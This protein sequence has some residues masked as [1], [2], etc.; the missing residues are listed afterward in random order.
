VSVPFNQKMK[1]YT[2]LKG[3]TIFLF[4]IAGVAL[5]LSIFF[6][7]FTKA[8]QLLLPLLIVVSYLLII[9]FLF[10]F[11]PATFFKNLRPSLCVY[12]V[13][14]SQVLEV[15]TWGMSFFYVIKA[16]G[17]FG[18]FFAFLF[19]FLAPM[20]LI[21]ATLKG[22]WA[23]AGHL[24]IWIS[25]TYGMKFYSQWLLNLNSRNQKKRDIIDVDA[26]EVQNS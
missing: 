1:V 18:I 11:L 21:G 25:F 20:A 26:I 3:F 17:F 15:A 5:F 10:G 24:S 19:Q 23:I 4:L 12:S 6:W 9:V 8:V 16:F 2:G 13:L 22:S 14:M 7:G